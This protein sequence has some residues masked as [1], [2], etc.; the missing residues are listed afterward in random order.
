MTLLGTKITQHTC[1]FPIG[2]LIISGLAPIFTTG[3]MMR[4]VIQ[5]GRS[6][7]DV[8]GEKAIP[9]DHGAHGENAMKMGICFTGKSILV[10][11]EDS[12]ATSEDPRF[13][14]FPF[15]P[16]PRDISTIFEDQN[17]RRCSSTESG[18]GQ[19]YPNFPGQSF[20]FWIV[21][22]TYKKYQKNRSP[23]SKIKGRQYSPSMD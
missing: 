19:N 23:P 22:G 11:Q 17:C 21:T 4:R 10:K 13:R 14:T 7:P 3:K 6:M 8:I 18:G 20:F 1:P 5:T 9:C 15:S 2:W 12:H 16:A